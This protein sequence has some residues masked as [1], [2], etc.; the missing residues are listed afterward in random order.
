MAFAQGTPDAEID[1]LLDRGFA[2]LKTGN[3][4]EMASLGAEA[5]RLSTAAHDQ[6]R[7][8]RSV[9]LIGSS[10]YSQGR[11]AEAL[12]E[13]QQAARL[14]A[15]LRD[16]P[17]Q[18]QA[19]R[20]IGNTLRQL[21]RYDEALRNLDEW[22]RLNRDGGGKE[23]E[24][25]MMRVV[26]V[27]YTEMGDLDKAESTCRGALGLARASGDRWLEAGTLF[28]LG[29]IMKD[30]S[31]PGEAISL[32]DQALKLAD[33]LH[34]TDL[35]AEILNSVG[36]A[37]LQSGDA[38]EAAK[39][40]NAA[41][42]LAR[43]LQY[44]GVEAEATERLGRLESLRGSYAEAIPMLARASALYREHGD[45]PDKLKDVE[46]VWARA[47]QSLG[48]REE[49]LSHYREAIALL[50]RLEQFTVPTEMARAFP[51]AE[52]RGI[53]EDAAVLLVEMN[54]PDEALDIAES[55][56]ARAFLDALNESKID[57]RSTLTASERAREDE[58]TRKLSGLRNNPGA[59]ANALA[60]L[61]A[62]YL[63]LRR[64]NPAYAQLRRPELAT[65]KQIQA[66]LTSGGTVFLEYMLGDKQSL[67]WAVDAK[68]I[69]FAVLPP[70]TEIQA[71]ATGWR[72][73][74]T[75]GVTALTAASLRAREDRQSRKLYD[76]L[77]APF[78]DEIGPAK[79]LLIAPDGALAY[80]PFEALL[81]P[82]DG[83]LLIEHC[84]ISYSQSASA[85]LELRTMRRNSPAPKEVLLA[86]GDAD[87][88]SAGDAKNRGVSWTPLPNTRNEVSGI[89]RL[90]AGGQGVSYLGADATAAQVKRQDLR[91]YRYLHFAVHGLVDED[92]PERSGL[93][94]SPD[95]TS[96]AG[97]LRMEEI[98]LFRTNADLV[99]LSACRTGIGRLLRGEG[100]MALSR[101]F[102]YAGAHN[103]I[104]TLWDVNDLSTARLMQDLYA[105]LNAGLAPEDALREA[106][107]RMLRGPWDL[108]RD[109]HF[110][111]PFIVLQ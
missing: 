50:E 13:L 57:L 70:R 40:L 102:F 62:F 26:C 60:E 67:A 100:L 79:H 49:A 10:S 23:P 95:R 15:E 106:K 72:G 5:L 22:F 39:C 16:I 98:A 9:L 56:R 33:T 43:S 83:K 75:P 32:L 109:P 63:N 105:Q 27:L 17:I 51:V 97:I 21:G 52:N 87:Y 44:R 86:F 64:S 93:V 2:D 48:H 41:V 96:P 35:R 45:V 14:A 92:N 71:L 78:A 108:W 94:L 74:L 110:W 90:Y 6:R 4:P 111:A 68:G 59:L 69:R 76:L 77:L 25:P 99:T 73:H 24:G 11:L 29:S 12:D 58:L 30:R 107:L 53:F 65:S 19:T 7:V 28:S 34:A 55:G 80:L 1:R 85:T 47:E 88:G 82:R 46:Y 61:E 8:A 31:R 38:T 42:E 91:D 101:A 20:G 104:A 66:E 36:D 81:S 3:Y 37:Y 84:S 54:R 89:S 103:V 18:K